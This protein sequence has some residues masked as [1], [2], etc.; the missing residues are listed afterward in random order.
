MLFL[1]SLVSS[2]FT[3]VVSALVA[4]SVAALASISVVAAVSA[5]VVAVL[6]VVDD[7]VVLVEAVSCCEQPVAVKA[8]ISSAASK[9]SE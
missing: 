5:P 8:T 3:S 7:V 4:V 1:V 2:V 6:S 9:F